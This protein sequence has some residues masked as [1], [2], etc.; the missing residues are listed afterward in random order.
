MIRRFFS[1]L[2]AFIGLRSR[3]QF[4]AGPVSFFA[5]R[6][7]NMPATH[8]PESPR[9]RMSTK[10]LSLRHWERRRKLMKTQ[11][12][13]RRINRGLYVKPGE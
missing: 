10:T 13:S 9:G 12:R 11:K 2:L 1:A 6:N 8:Q 4:T 5:E 3:K 7:A